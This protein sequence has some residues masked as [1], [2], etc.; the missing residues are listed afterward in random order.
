MR[1]GDRREKGKLQ[2]RV[3]GIPERL[4]RSLSAAAAVLGCSEQEIVEGGIVLYC[5]YVLNRLE[6]ALESA[7]VEGKEVASWDPK[8]LV[9]GLGSRCVSRRGSRG[10]LSERRRRIG[11]QSEITS[12]GSV[13]R[14]LGGAK[15]K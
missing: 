9:L 13:L 5:T 12:V 4:C 3:F 15:P 11:G 7:R 2:G 8:E 14:R 10:G 1:K 6:P